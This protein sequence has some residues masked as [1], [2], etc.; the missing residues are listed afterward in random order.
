VKKITIISV[1]VMALTWLCFKNLIKGKGKGKGSVRA[2]AFFIK[3]FVT[4][5]RL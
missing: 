5:K 1:V 4:N 2:F 3:K